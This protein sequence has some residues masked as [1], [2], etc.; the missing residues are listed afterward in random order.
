MTT[1]VGAWERK[2][3]ICLV[4]VSIDRDIFTNV[5]NN[6]LDENKSDEYVYKITLP[7][8]EL[9]HQHLTSS[10]NEKFICM[11]VWGYEKQL[12][13]PFSSELFNDEDT[14]SI[15]KIVTQFIEIS[16]QCCSDGFEIVTFNEKN[17]LLAFALQA[18]CENQIMQ[19][20]LK[21]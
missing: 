21:A 18:L 17:K 2:A 19:L 9:A 14:E 12:Y 6:L 11:F 20:N 3:K 7:Q 16:I 13:L 10:N 1:T 5:L 15:Q 4:D 8:I